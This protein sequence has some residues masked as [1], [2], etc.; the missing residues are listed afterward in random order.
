M[1]MQYFK[2][3]RHLD[4]ILENKKWGLSLIWKIIIYSVLYFQSRMIKYLKRICCHLYFFLFHYIT[5]QNFLLL[6]L[7][8]IYLEYPL[9]CKM[10][11]T[12]T[13]FLGKIYD[14]VFS[15]YYILRALQRINWHQQKKL[16]RTSYIIKIV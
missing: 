4:R 7:F 5:F 14:S 6:L 9:Q 16:I 8:I 1:M 12:F 3:D 10:G 15:D 11:C 13:D 2:I